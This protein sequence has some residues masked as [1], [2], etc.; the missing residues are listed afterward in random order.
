VDEMSVEIDWK[1]LIDGGDINS[2]E[3]L[4]E[5]DNFLFVSGFEVY[6]NIE[7][8]RMSLVDGKLILK[9]KEYGY[10][11]HDGMKVPF[12]PYYLEAD[13]DKKAY[14][15][16]YENITKYVNKR[17]IRIINYISHKDMKFVDYTKRS[18]R[19]FRNKFKDRLEII[20]VDKNNIKEYSEEVE[21]IFKQWKKTREEQN[22]IKNPRFI[23]YKMAFKRGYEYYDE[24]DYYL[25]KIDNTAV[26][27]S[28]TVPVNDFMTIFEINMTLDF[29]N[30]ERLVGIGS[31]MY[32]F[33][34]R[35][36]KTDYRCMGWAAS[37]GLI[38]F[39]KRFTVNILPMYYTDLFRE[40]RNDVKSVESWFK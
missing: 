32:A 15:F 35:Y 11:K 5:G 1:Y 16:D 29:L 33:G 21:N 40:V 3:K 27:Y 25:F 24:M 34:T 13:N 28:I 6:E 20:K 31:F 14:C 36:N 22:K 23:P 17:S 7:A 37:E 10:F 38:E 30:E 8:N 9:N 2:G 12:K 39:K 4:W 26:A 19:K 18:L